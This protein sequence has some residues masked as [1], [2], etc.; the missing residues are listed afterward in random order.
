MGLQST[1]PLFYR[2]YLIEEWY[3]NECSLFL[4]IFAISQRLLWPG[5]GAVELGLLPLKAFWVKIF[6]VF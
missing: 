4:A 3:C 6:P 2:I 5:L 1:F